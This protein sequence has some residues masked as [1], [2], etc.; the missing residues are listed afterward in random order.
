MNKPTTKIHPFQF[1]SVLFASMLVGIL[2]NN[3]AHAC[4]VQFFVYT[5]SDSKPVLRWQAAMQ[6][7]L[8]YYHIVKNINGKHDKFQHSPSE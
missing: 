8:G 2:Q 1:M 4:Y 5:A 3:C 7:S 6:A